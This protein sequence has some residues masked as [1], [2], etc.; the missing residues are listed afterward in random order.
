IPTC[1]KG[2]PL[3]QAEKASCAL[4]AAQWKKSE[5]VL[6]DTISSFLDN[7]D[8]KMKDIGASHNVTKAHVKKLITYHTHYKKSHGPQLFNALVHAKN[9]EVNGD[10]PVGSKLKIQEI[11]QMVTHDPAMHN[12]VSQSIYATTST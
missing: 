10:H 1:L 8:K 6:S 4:K 11:R 5:K 12:V 3:T 9:Q 7:Q 2:A